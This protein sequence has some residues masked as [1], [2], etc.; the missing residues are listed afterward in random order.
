[1]APVNTSMAYSELQKQ[2]LIGKLKKNL[3]AKQQSSGADT[4]PVKPEADSDETST[5]APGQC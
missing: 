5:T 3:A 4:D 2:K 1:M